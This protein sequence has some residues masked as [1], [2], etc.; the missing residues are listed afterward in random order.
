M[1][2]DLPKGTHLDHIVF[3]VPGLLDCQ[4][5]I[6]REEGTDHLR[7]KAL[8]TFKD[9]KEVPTGVVIQRADTGGQ[10]FHTLSLFTLHHRVWIESRDVSCDGNIG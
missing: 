6:Y 2:W 1:S 10:A 8:P 5:E 4:S 3:G 9:S 7:V